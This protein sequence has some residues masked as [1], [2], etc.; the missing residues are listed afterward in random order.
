MSEI[1][2]LYEGDYTGEGSVFLFNPPAYSFDHDVT[3]TLVAPK[4]RERLLS[5]FGSMKDGFNPFNK[6]EILKKENVFIAYTATNKEF[7]PPTVPLWE[8]LV[9]EEE[10]KTAIIGN[11]HPALN[12]SPEARAF[13]EEKRNNAND[14]SIAPAYGHHDL[15]ITHSQEND[16]AEMSPQNAR[17]IVQAA[18][19]WYNY[20]AQ[21][22]MIQ[23]IMWFQNYGEQGGRTVDH[24][25]SQLMA[26]PITNRYTFNRV[27]ETAKVYNEYRS[28]YY[29]GLIIHENEDFIAFVPTRPSFAFDVNILPKQER[30]F[31][32]ELK[33]ESIASLADA[34][35]KTL[36]AITGLPAF[37]KNE[38]PDEERFNDM[39]ISYNFALMSSVRRY[40]MWYIDVYARTQHLGGAETGYNLPSL[41]ILPQE[42]AE[43]LRHCIPT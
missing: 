10:W 14:I 22:K 24:P 33:T 25:H 13:Y 30:Y 16:I 6:P 17:Q 18:S 12:N 11:K 36:Q 28:D 29:R 26:L 35:Q 2:P 8:T 31:F 7:F 19:R 43:I 38:Y 27:M 15:I 39:Q 20:H 34:L 4:R 21:D 37:F 3:A 23:E 5:N 32:S 1:T 40:D 9:D 42:S 41:G